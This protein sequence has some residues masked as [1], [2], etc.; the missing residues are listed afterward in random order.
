MVRQQD[1]IDT[2]KAYLKNCIRGF[3]KETEK[4]QPN[5][6][7]I[8]QYDDEDFANTQSDDEDVEKFC[9]EVRPHLVDFLRSAVSSPDSHQETGIAK[10]QFI[11]GLLPNLLKLG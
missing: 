9:A 11:F 5:I 8:A 10:Q 1:L 4:E 7:A 3:L 6:A 2:A